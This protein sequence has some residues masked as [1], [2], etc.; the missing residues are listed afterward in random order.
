MGEGVSMDPGSEN[1]WVYWSHIRA[2]FYV[3]SYA[4]GL[5]ISRSLQHKYKEDHSFM[6]HIKEFLSA[7]TSDSPY[8]IFM[9]MGIDIKDEKFWLDGL[10]QVSENLSKAKN[11]AVKLGK[12]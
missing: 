12:I 6:N 2:F 11:L 8:N 1:W 7:G 5:L 3:Y 9:K 4:S 10:N